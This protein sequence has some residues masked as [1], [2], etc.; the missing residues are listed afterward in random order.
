MHAT[1]DRSLELQTEVISWIEIAFENIGFKQM[2]I[3]FPKYNITQIKQLQEPG[4]KL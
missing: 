4:I 1:F 3:N 2:Y